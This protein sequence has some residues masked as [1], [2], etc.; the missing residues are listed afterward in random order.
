M[1]AR[2]GSPVSV[3]Q[4]DMTPLRHSNLLLGITCLFFAACAKNVDKPSALATGTHVYI[5]GD[6]GNSPILWTDEAEQVLSPSKGSAGQVVKSGNDVYVAG[7]CGESGS[8]NPGGPG[9]VYAYWKNGRQTD[10]GDTVLLHM[11]SSIAIAG[12]SL[13]FSNGSVW[14]NGAS[15]TL[16]EQGTYGQVR[17]LFAAG[18]D[19]YAVGNDNSNNVVY[20]KN[21]QPITVEKGDPNS[22]Y[23]LAD[24]IYVSGGDVYVGGFDA[25]GKPAYWKN[26]VVTE[27]QPSDPGTLVSQAISIF[28]HGSDV[29]V[30]GNYYSPATYLQPAYFKNGVQQNLP[31]NGAK[32]GRA[33]DI[34]VSD[35]TVYVVGSTADGAVYWKNGVETVLSPV[36]SAWSVVV[37]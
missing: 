19:I 13:Y 14:L 5:A 7:V 26:G 11:Q 17:E 1:S 8:L 22:S 31:L 33:N 12:G 24:C 2:N 6:D 25:A 9:G 3:V 35:S 23:P 18:N 30:V 15:G 10:M 28:V 32:F 37:Q 29:Y 27:L 20:W 36:G 21:G 16:P 4:P 34:F